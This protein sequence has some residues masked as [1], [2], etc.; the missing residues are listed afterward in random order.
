MIQYLSCPKNLL[1]LS[2]QLLVAGMLLL[3]AGVGG[4]YGLDGRLS[5][6]ALVVAH[7]GVIVGPTLLKIGYVLRLIV[8]HLMRKVDWEPCCASA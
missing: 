7:C 8:Q 5:I 1:R 3:L 2:T 4:A 6:P